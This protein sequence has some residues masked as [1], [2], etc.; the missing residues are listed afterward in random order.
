VKDTA[1]GLGK[2]LFTT[3]DGRR[4]L[5]TVFGTLFGKK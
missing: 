1:I 5:R 3:A 2:D 4:T